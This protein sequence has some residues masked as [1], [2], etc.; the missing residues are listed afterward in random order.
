MTLMKKRDLHVDRAIE[1]GLPMRSWVAAVSVTFELELSKTVTQTAHSDG[2]VDTQLRRLS[3]L[4]ADGVTTE[5][6]FSEKRASVMKH[7]A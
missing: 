5:E 4:R 1:N 7:L 6:E 3:Q 2:D